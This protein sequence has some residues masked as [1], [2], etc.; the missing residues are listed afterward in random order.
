MAGSFQRGER[1]GV[2]P[3]WA[4]VP[5]PGVV[6]CSFLVLV[7]VV[8]RGSAGGGQG[9]DMGAVAPQQRPRPLHGV[10]D[11]V[12]PADQRFHPRQSPPLVLPA[13]G[14][15]TALQLPLQPCHLH[16]RQPR[17]TRRTLGGDA[18]CTAFAPGPPPPAPR[19]APT[20]A[21]RQRCPGS[22][23]R[24]RIGPRLPTGSSPEPLSR[25]RSNRRPAHTSQTAAV[26]ARQLNPQVNAPTSQSSPVARQVVVIV[27]CWRSTEDCSLWTISSWP[28]SCQALHPHPLVVGEPMPH[29]AVCSRPLGMT[30]P[31]RPSP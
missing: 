19:I 29:R 20:P 10:R 24:P 17:P 8:R 28:Y 4:A 30:V 3:W 7:G 16:I 15:R 27:C 5:R 1:D 26:P 9:L 25:R 6:R 11:V 12:Q 22:S 31:S 21:T 23:P 13:V 14:Q 18:L 2:T